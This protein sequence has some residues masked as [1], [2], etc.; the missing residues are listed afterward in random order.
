MLRQSAPGPSN[1]PQGGS[2]PSNVPPGDAPGS[3]RSPAGPSGG[4][5]QSGAAPSSSGPSPGAPAAGPQSGSSPGL[6]NQAL[7]AAAQNANSNMSF[8]PVG[9]GTAPC[10]GSASPPPSSNYPDGGVNA[11]TDKKH[12]IAIELVDQNG[13]PVPGEEYQITLPDGSPVEGDLDASGFARIDGID[14]GTC[15]VSFPNLNG[16]DWKRA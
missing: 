6:S 11:P 8:D 13:K 5:A 10:P 16:R 14:P 4:A 1:S 9:D 7:D 12:W 2:A 3:T 15:S